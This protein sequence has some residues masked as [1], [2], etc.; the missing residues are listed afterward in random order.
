[1]PEPTIDIGVLTIR[2]DEFKAVLKAFPDDQQIY[3]TR[4]C[5][6]AQRTAD[7]GQGR[8]YRLAILRQIE[9]GNGEAQEAARDLIDDF[10]PSLLLVVGVAGGLPSDDLSLGDVVLSTR[11]VDFSLEAHKFQEQTTYNLGGGPIPKAIATGV[12]N[13]AAREAELGEWWHSLP[14]KPKMTLVV[15][16]GRKRPKLDHPASNVRSGLT[17][18]HATQ[19]P[20]NNPNTAQIIA[21]MMPSL[22]GSS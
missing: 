5:E 12:A 7:A 22:V 4:H 1:M 2:D 8:R 3:Q 18:S 13:L 9:Q 11:I 10:H 6:Y 16:T 20:M 15:C 19:S 21:R 17:S 14:P